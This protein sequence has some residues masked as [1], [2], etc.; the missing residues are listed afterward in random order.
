MNNR[1]ASAKVVL[2]FERA[3]TFLKIL[4]QIVTYY[5]DICPGFAALASSH[6][7]QMLRGCGF[8]GYPVRG[9][10]Q[11]GSQRFPH[12]GNVRGQFGT[13]KGD[14]DI[15]I[16][17]PVAFPVDQ[18][19][20][21]GQQDFTVDAFPLGRCVREKMADVPQRQGPQQGVA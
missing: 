10:L 9:H 8:D 21:F 14:G 15:G 12:G 3:N 20:H 19:R 7:T 11:N 5:H 16:A 4:L 1:F 6:K 17:N 13:L 18:V 2:I